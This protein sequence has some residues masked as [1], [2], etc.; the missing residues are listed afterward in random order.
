MNEQEVIEQLQQY[1]QKRARMELLSTYSVGAGITI[2]RLNQD[3]QLQELHRRLRGLPSYMYL[4]GYE[5]K[6]E[7]TAHAYLE[8]YPAGIK[9]QLSVIPKHSCDEEDNKLL[10]DLKARIQKVLEARGYEIRN[11][12]DTVLDRVAELQDLQEEIE[13]IDAILLALGRLNPDFP[14]LLRRKYIDGEVWSTVAGELHLS[15]PVF[16]RRREKAIKEYI[17]LAG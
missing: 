6:L 17:K 3:D 1:R 16:F 11:D 5:Q 14:I 4:S 7:T 12:I 9:S 2:S 15:K 10:H 13:R 8:R